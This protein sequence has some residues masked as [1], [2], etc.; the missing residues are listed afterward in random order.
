MK[1]P[2]DHDGKSKT[3]SAV[4]SEHYPEQ[5]EVENTDFDV[6]SSQPSHEEIA[7]RA[8]ELWKAR[9]APQG[10]AHEDWYEAERELREAATSR[11]VIRS[12]ARGSGSV[13]R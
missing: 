11:N 2:T 10:S 4:D 13:Q 3:A 6:L 9:G 1:Y 7:R 8:F 12:T 5:N